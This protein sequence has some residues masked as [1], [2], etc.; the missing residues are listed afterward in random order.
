MEVQMMDAS[1]PVEGQLVKAQ[2]EMRWCSLG[3][4]YIRELPQCLDPLPGQ[5]YIKDEFSAM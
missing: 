4:P 2:Q 5:K 1:L 3:S